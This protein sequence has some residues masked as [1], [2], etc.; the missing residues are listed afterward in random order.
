VR[1]L[2]RSEQ[3]MGLLKEKGNASIV[4]LARMLN[5]SESSVRR[6]IDYM[7]R[8]GKYQNVQRVHG[9]II[10]TEKPS[11]LEYM[12]ELK[13]DLN[14]GLKKEIARKAI[15]YVKDGDSIII[16]SGTSCLSFVELLGI[17]KGLKVISVDIKI[18]EEL[19]KHAEFESSIIGGVIRPGYYTVGGNSALENLNHFHSEKAFMSTDAIDLHHGLSN[20]SEFEVGVKRKIIKN[21]GQVILLVDHTKFNKISLYKVADL[22]EKF[23]IITNKEIDPEIVRQFNEAGQHIVL[24]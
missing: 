18:A 23:L 14:S 20:T 8:L 1:R 7:I 24:A 2:A 16:D 15:E 19:G 13:V 17:R 11:E 4:Y 12:F 22:D 10:L 9:G 6:D 5:V 3:V 21:A